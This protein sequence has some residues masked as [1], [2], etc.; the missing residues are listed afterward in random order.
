MTQ[1]FF[2]FSGSIL[3]LLQ[4]IGSCLSGYAQKYYGKKSCVVLACVPS[5]CGWILLWYADSVNMLYLS[6]MTMGLGLGFNDGPAYS[7]I[8]EVCEPRL[9]G[10]MSCVINMACLIG[11]LSTYGLGSIF[12]WKTVASLSGLCPV[13]CLLLVTFVSNIIYT[14]ILEFDLNKIDNQF[15]YNSPFPCVYLSFV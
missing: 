8:G 1:T 14:K 2:I 15:A 9:R 5:I 7:Y 13:L 3:Y 12:H 11:I 6:T 4:P 10:I